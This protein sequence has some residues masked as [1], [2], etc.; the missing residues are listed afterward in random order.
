MVMSCISNTVGGP[1]VGDARW[2]GV[3][4][5]AL[6]PRAEPASSAR[7]VMAH[8]ADGYFDVAPLAVARNPETLVAFGMDGLLLPREHGF[9]ARLLLPGR[10]GFKS[11]KWLQEI[12]VLT[13]DAIGY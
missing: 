8:G 7:A 11:V 4:L 5:A 10:Y 2:I 6:L 9:P 12:E 1:L 3:S 13:T